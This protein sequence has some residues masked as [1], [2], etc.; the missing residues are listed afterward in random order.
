MTC[1]FSS[2]LLEPNSTFVVHHSAATR[3]ALR[4]GDLMAGFPPERRSP[5]AAN[6]PGSVGSPVPAMI[7]EDDD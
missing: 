6:D 1:A 3:E 4:A 2:G 5:P 7:S